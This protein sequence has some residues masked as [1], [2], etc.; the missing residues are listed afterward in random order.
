MGFLGAATPE[1][2][3]P[4]VTAH[5]FGQGMET[6][7]HREAVTEGYVHGGAY[8]RAAPRRANRPRESNPHCAG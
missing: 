5:G 6:G 4:C 1:R 2:A 7:G 3:S 8:L